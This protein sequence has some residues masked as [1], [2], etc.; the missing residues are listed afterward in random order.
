MVAIVD[1]PRAE[2]P[3][4]QATASRE[5]AARVAPE[6]PSLGN[7]PTLGAL[8]ALN[9]N[10]LSL[11]TGPTSFRPEEV[12]SAERKFLADSLMKLT[13]PQEQ[14]SLS[15]LDTGKIVAA[16]MALGVA[17]AAAMQ[18]DPKQVEAEKKE[19]ERKAKEEELKKVAEREREAKEKTEEYARKQEELA[20]SMKAQLL[21]ANKLNAD[22]KKD[23]ILAKLK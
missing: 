9:G 8:A 1:T 2:S 14:D 3:V 21:E 5:P 10:L 17:I 20:R 11:A 22:Q 7:S 23:F 12:K 16:G 4:P 18:K 6:T 13:M 15:K 19:A